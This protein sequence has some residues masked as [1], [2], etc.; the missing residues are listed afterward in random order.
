MIVRVRVSKEE[1]AAFG[2]TCCC[3]DLPLFAL[4][5]DFTLTGELLDVHPM[6]HAWEALAAMGVEAFA[7]RLGVEL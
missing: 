7:G 5:F 4:V 2:K 6:G 1:V 3:A